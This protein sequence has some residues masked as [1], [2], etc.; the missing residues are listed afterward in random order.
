MVLHIFSL[1]IAAENY[2]QRENTR[3]KSLQPHQR[4]DF[5]VKL[6]KNVLEQHATQVK[7]HQFLSQ[8]DTAAILNSF[9]HEIRA[10]VHTSRSKRLSAPNPQEWSETE[11]AKWI[12]WTRSVEKALYEFQPSDSMLGDP[13]LILFEKLQVLSDSP[14]LFS[15]LAGRARELLQKWERDGVFNSTF[16][17]DTDEDDDQDR[18]QVKTYHQK[19]ARARR[20]RAMYDDVEIDGYLD[21][22]LFRVYSSRKI[23]AMWIIKRNVIRWSRTRKMSEE[24][25]AFGNTTQTFIRQFNRSG[26]PTAA[27]EAQVDENL[28]G[29]RGDHGS[30]FI[31]M[32]ELMH[33]SRHVALYS[34]DQA[35]RE[36]E[37][38]KQKYLLRRMRSA[39]KIQMAWK[40]SCQG[41]RVARPK[42]SRTRHK[43]MQRNENQV[44][45]ARDT[46]KLIR[47]DSRQPPPKQNITKHTKHA[48]QVIREHPATATIDESKEGVIHK[49]ASMLLKR[50]RKAKLLQS[51]VN[52]IRAASFLPT[53]P[54]QSE[55]QEHESSRQPSSTFRPWETDSI[56]SN[57]SVS[58]EFVDFSDGGQQAIDPVK[59][60]V[61]T[62]PVVDNITASI[63][64]S[65]PMSTYVESRAPED[66]RS[67]APN[68]LTK[69][70]SIKNESILQSQFKSV[71]N[72][73]AN[74]IR[75]SSSSSQS[76][77]QWQRPGEPSRPPRVILATKTQQV[78]P[79][80]SFGNS[81][82][83]SLS[84]KMSRP[85]TLKQLHRPGTPKASTAIP[86]KQPKLSSLD[87]THT[88][89]QPPSTKSLDHIDRLAAFSETFH[90]NRIIKWTAQRLMTSSVQ[91]S[92]MR[93]SSASPA[94]VHRA[95]TTESATTNS[96][97]RGV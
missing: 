64:S 87:T 57:T 59:D 27:K 30:A 41:S 91:D 67:S 53:R 50:M 78:V 23:T 47:P 28:R 70:S 26:R 16:S 12:G 86:L 14:P 58:S 62:G 97:T 76:F 5:G 31:L 93:R 39:Y 55:A 18:M 71:T 94:K 48:P 72:E 81:D 61:G 82:T 1:S 11:E 60:T 74:A 89:A 83:H 6:P 22:H 84:S 15:E 7:H 68:K 73:P 69:L 34:V 88:T 24:V 56:A 19:E 85:S 38:I 32:P 77:A 33:F 42:R 36:V 8:K 44:I 49:Q 9:V 2:I 80:D 25:E 65:N 29:G 92:C 51:S 20:D 90:S 21:H 79:F 75:E 10:I 63:A 35:L 96:L 52:A 54:I 46:L 45:R 43:K 13:L 4:N 40:N 3:R 95:P 17:S 37:R 66:V